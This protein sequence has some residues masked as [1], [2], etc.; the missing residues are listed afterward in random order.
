[1]AKEDGKIE[2][3]TEEELGVIMDVIST[4]GFYTQAEVV[5]V[6]CPACGDEF[7]GTKRHAGEFISGHAAYHD[8]V[9]KQDMISNSRGG[10]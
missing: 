4:D 10:V 1:M 7:L 9:N 6:T 8:F 5:H 3:L 2:Q